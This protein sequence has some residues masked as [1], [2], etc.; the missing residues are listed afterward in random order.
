MIIIILFLLAAT[1]RHKVLYH[2]E[3]VDGDMMMSS[4]FVQTCL[5]YSLITT[6]IFTSNGDGVVQRERE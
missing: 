4:I 6:T 1:P 3:E 2:Y 5:H